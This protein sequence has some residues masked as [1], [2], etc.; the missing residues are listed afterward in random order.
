MKQAVG[1]ARRYGQS[2]TVNVYHLVTLHSIDVDILQHRTGRVLVKV[3]P[4]C[5]LVDGANLLKGSQLLGSGFG[6][7]VVGS[8]E[9]E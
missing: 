6:H 4:N 8:D 5:Q 9:E 3:G 2:K 7:G 1:R